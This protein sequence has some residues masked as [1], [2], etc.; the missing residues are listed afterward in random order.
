MTNSSN[1]LDENKRKWLTIK[2]LKRKGYYNVLLHSMLID[3]C[4]F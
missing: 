4:G 3:W 1:E 2:K